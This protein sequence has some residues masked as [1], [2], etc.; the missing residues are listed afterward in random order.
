M[1]RDKANFAVLE[2]LITVLT[3]E[4]VKIVEILESEGNQENASD[5][6][7]RVDI[8]A[9][10]ERGDIIIVEVQL[11]R[12]LYYL[13]RILYGVSKT[14][15]EHIG[16]GD[17]YDEVKKVYSINI[18]YFDL[19]QG[20]DYLYHGKTVFTGV[21]TGDLLK[22][23]TREKE[24]IKMTMPTDI[25]PEY[26]IVR[27]NEFNDVAR[28]PL[29]EWLDYLKNNRIKDDTSTPGLKEARQRL[30]Y[31][32]MSDADRKAYLAHMDNLRVQKDVLDTAKL[33]GHAEGLAEG[34]AEGHAEGLAEGRA[35]GLVEGMEK[36]REQGLAE[37]IAEGMEKG[38]VASK[39]EIAKNMKAAGLDAQTIMQF[40]GL[41]Q[42]QI[43]QL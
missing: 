27:V 17:T 5:K 6:F 9:K 8:K 41:D 20:S 7:N 14:I 31:L 43:D 23:N 42:A 12:Q 37:G 1:L 29:E 36:G 28:T 30:L 21:H 39:I 26:Y 24:G 2:G 32:T 15:T 11:T 19:G 33:E 40:T 10:N 38:V 22:V 3:G 35:E 4:Q 34:R 18:D 25:F 13:R 16:L